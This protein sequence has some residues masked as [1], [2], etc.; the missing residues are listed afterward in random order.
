MYRHAVGA[1]L[2]E[3]GGID[4]GTVHFLTTSN[5]EYV[6]NACFLER[7]GEE[8]AEAQRVLATF[9]QTHPQVVEEAGRSS[10]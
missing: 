2:E 10:T 6:E 1:L 5:G 4:I 8:L 3:G 9:P 7:L